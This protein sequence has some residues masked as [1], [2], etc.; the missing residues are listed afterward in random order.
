M[1]SFPRGVMALTTENLGHQPWSISTGVCPIGAKVFAAYGINE[2]P[3]LLMKA[4]T[5]RQRR[6][7]I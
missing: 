5:A 4:T 6:A 3:L 1:Y 2:K 7:G